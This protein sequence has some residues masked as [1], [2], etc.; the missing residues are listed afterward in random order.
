MTMDMGIMGT[1]KEDY[2]NKIV[3]LTLSNKNLLGKEII[4]TNMVTNENYGGKTMS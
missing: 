4:S 2:Q 3:T 1:I